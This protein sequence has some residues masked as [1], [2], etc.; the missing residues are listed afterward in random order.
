MGF[1]VN[2]Q[3]R[4]I[5][6]VMDEN[7]LYGEDWDRYSSGG[8]P[9]SYIK[10]VPIWLCVFLVIGYIVGGALLF[11]SWEGW[12]L[13]DSA[14]FCFITL[15]TIGSG[16]SFMALNYKFKLWRNGGKNLIQF[17]SS[18]TTLVHEIEKLSS[19]HS[20]LFLFSFLW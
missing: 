19:T 14:Y 10:P 17:S 20:F 16:T 12:T 2:R 13:L 4:H 15:T 9:M 11:S 5:A 8:P 1:A 3:A 7:S 18:Y 6:S